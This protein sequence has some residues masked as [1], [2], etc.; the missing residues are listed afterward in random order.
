MDDEQKRLLEEL[1]FS[2]EKK[3]SFAKMLYFGGFHTP[4]AFPF[5][6]P[7]AE[8]ERR[9]DELVTKTQKF[10]E[11]KVN[12]DQFDRDSS[13]PDDVFK[14]LGRLG[15]LSLTVS[16]EYGGSEDSQYAYGRVIAEL[17]KACGS[18]ALFVNAHQSI[19]LRALVLF[20]TEEQK[21]KWLPPL[22]KG[23]IYAAFS[24]TEANAGS[25]AGGVET[26]A[27]YNAEKDV[28]VL[29][30]D[31]QWTTNG[32][33]AG[34]LTVMARTEIETDNGIE[35][36]ITAF[37]VTPDM[38]GFTVRDRA[39]E[40]VGMRGTTTSN[41][42][43]KDMEVPASN[44]LGPKGGGLKVALTVLDYGRTTFG[45]A[46]AGPARM[47]VKKA[48]EHAKTRHQFK[49][50]LASFGMVKQILARAGAYSYAMSA[51]AELV[52]GLLDRGDD[53]ILL[54]SAIVKVFN[55]EWLW[56]IIYD[57]MQI[58]G[59]RSFFTTE[60]L[61]RM[62]RDARLNMIGEGSNEVLRAF[63]AVV[64]LRDV[65]M[66]F[67]SV[68]EALKH[69]INK[70]GVLKSFG[71]Q[72]AHYFKA[73]DIPIK[74]SHM[75]EEA[76][77]LGKAIRRFAVANARVLAKY[78]EEIVEHQLAL[79]RISDIVMALFTVTAV[80]SKLD[81]QLSKTGDINAQL[82]QD[83]ACGKLYC[84]YAFK[85]IDNALATL[86]NNIDSDIES[87]ADVMS[88]LGQ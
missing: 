21:N 86:F 28:Y 56:Q 77:L 12:G 80:I 46:C 69:P 26:R 34:V 16:K 25:D 37:L 83:L 61:E 57:T 73:P 4:S 48:V 58:Y 54:E 11:A 6:L 7:S 63:I 17:A 55:S 67:Q 50:P 52:T 64:G 71:K 20:G 14:E 82:K 60:P 51:S 10:I 41:I 9:A 88:G 66:Q 23:E 43:F 1:L 31:K 36:K 85:T 27:V 68:Q 8:E 53:D 18:T 49:R 81:T 35:D 72:G 32:A 22:A 44:I 59:G 47:L 3:L 76:H 79:D 75:A 78:R 42:S 65:G 15:L 33:I 30:G 5:P 70:F 24:L 62:M 87:V 84:K 29:N 45:S 74:T 19:G 40:K 38:P 13:I 2:G 39:L